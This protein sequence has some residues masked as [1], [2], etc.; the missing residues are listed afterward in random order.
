VSTGTITSF[1]GLDGKKGL[2]V[3]QTFTIVT[4]TDWKTAR[5]RPFE[6]ELFDSQA[7]S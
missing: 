4:P 2:H 6:R 1:F 5:V 3:S 7:T